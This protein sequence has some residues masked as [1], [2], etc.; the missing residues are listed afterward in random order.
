VGQP[1]LNQFVTEHLAN[2]VSHNLTPVETVLCV[3]HESDSVPR[4]CSADLTQNP[5][6]PQLDYLTV[7]TLSRRPYRPA[8]THTI[9]PT[10]CTT[11]VSAVALQP[12]PILGGGLVN[13][14]WSEGGGVCRGVSPH[15]RHPTER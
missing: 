7:V 1:A 10:T 14:A 5:G 12:P 4:P 15:L 3:H 8:L 11:P 6:A 9:T 13:Y 2:G